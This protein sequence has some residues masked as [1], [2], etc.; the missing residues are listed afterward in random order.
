MRRS[1]AAVAIVAYATT[2]ELLD[3]LLDAHELLF[4]QNII[5]RQSHVGQP[6][7]ECCHIG[8]THAWPDHLNVCK[9]EEKAI[10][11]VLQL[12]RRW[13]WQLNSSSWPIGNLQSVLSGTGVVCSAQGCADGADYISGISI[14][15]AQPDLLVVL[16]Y[17]RE[18]DNCI[19]YWGCIGI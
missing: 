12:H 2:A 6:E 9:F 4:L 14:S 10:A 13:I 5:E 7:E 18:N 11:S 3:E 16:I 8:S 1:W 19:S 17:A 15:S